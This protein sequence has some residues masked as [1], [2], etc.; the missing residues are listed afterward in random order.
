MIIDF[1]KLSIKDTNNNIEN[2]IFQI[3][4]ESQFSE[5]IQP[6]YTGNTCGPR[7]LF[8]CYKLAEYFDP[9][10]NADISDTLD[11]LKNNTNNEN[12]K[13][14]DN[15]KI[16]VF[17]DFAG[18]TLNKKPTNLTSLDLE[19]IIKTNEFVKDIFNVLEGYSYS[20][21]EDSIKID[22]TISIKEKNPGF[23]LGLIIKRDESEIGLTFE[24]SAS[25]IDHWICLFLVKISNNKYAW[26][27]AD[28]LNKKERI[29]NNDR[30]L[31]YIHKFLGKNHEPYEKYIE[32]NKI[33]A[34]EKQDKES[35]FLINNEIKSILDNDKYN[36]Y[37]THKNIIDDIISDKI[38]ALYNLK[39][40]D[41]N[42]IYALCFNIIK[43]IKI[44]FN[45]SKEKIALSFLH[46]DISKIKK[47]ISNQ[48]N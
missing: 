20:F 26:F 31:A 8:N 9:K 30:F 17:L 4:V 38:I 35:F 40:F 1:H 15:K 13:I 47:C 18:A 29:E 44:K 43:D 42:K 34:R 21:G 28:S 16:N 41:V 25:S 7:A 27:I 46:L 10:T 12:K 19:N 45:L 5:K 37:E 2:Y 24:E 22:Q 32:K 33:K 3:K 14:D 39:S 11:L 48:I 23:L 36:S 6:P